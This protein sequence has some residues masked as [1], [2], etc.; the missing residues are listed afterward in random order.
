MH[1]FHHAA[2][3]PDKPACI[4]ASTGE[5]VSYRDL[6][7]A[8]NQ[9]ANL[10]RYLGL[11][12]G[13]VIAVMLEN[14]LPLFEIAWGAQ[15]SG[16]YLTTVST[17]L[18]ARDIS[19]ILQDAGCK[20]FIFSDNL[21]ALA[22]EALACLP[23]VKGFGVHTGG[24]SYQSWK[25]LSARQPK[26]RIVDES[27]GTDMLY[28]SGTTG[29]PKGVRGPLPDG[30]IDASIALMSMGCSLYGMDGDMVYLSTSPLYHAAPL[31]WAMLAHRLG[32]TVVVMAKFDA[33]EA[34]RLIQ[35]Y[36]VTHSTWVPTHFI[37]M[38]KLSEHVRAAYDLGSMRAVI[39]SAAPC[40]VEVKR[41]MIDWFGP[42]IHEYYSGTEQC[43]I[44][45]LDSEEWLRKPGS[46]GRAVIGKPKILDEDGHEVATGTVGQVFFADGS[47]FAYHNDPEKTALAYNDRG[48]ATLGDIGYLDEEGYL[49]LTDRKHFMI[50]SG[51]VNIYPQEIENALVLH[52]KVNDVAVIGV[53]D[54]EMGEAVLAIVQP[55]E[56]VDGDDTVAEELRRFCREAVGAIKTPKRFLFRDTL[57]R[58]ATGKL[59]K[60]KLI[61][62]FR[63]GAA[64]PR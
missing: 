25:S 50:I 32:A 35:R 27:A 12:R 43:G 38:L 11:K 17:R 63:S 8:S 26:D 24:D 40:P 58:E 13:D 41:Q 5:S 36:R 23:D 39:H 57:P 22:A 4:L 14:E 7:D 15:R 6:E 51:G 9:S 55:R 29:R 21:A 20:I 47:P 62:E 56:G 37:R 49:F 33:E 64:A 60:T 28:S 45:A 59:M 16:C 30:A 10:I 61:E 1:P 53:P 44:T 42:I 52:P 19:Y 46:V 2:A 54:E 31:R 34:L 48:W 3:N 18:S